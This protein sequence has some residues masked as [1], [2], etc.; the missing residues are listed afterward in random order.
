MHRRRLTVVLVVAASLW[1]AGSARPARTAGPSLEP[2]KV[3]RWVAQHTAA[4]QPAEFLVVLAE[5][6]DLRGAASL[7][8]RKAKG[9]F[10]H[11]ALLQ[12]A[13]ETQ[14]PLLAWLEANRIPHRSFYIANLIWV[15][16]DSAVVQALAARPEVAR[17]E[18]NPAIANSVR[19][20]TP[21]VASAQPNGVE[22]N[23]SYVHADA[24]WAQGFTG[25]GI[26]IGGQDTGYQWDH[27]ALK[28]HYRGWNGST[29]SHDYNW[30]DSIHTDN[31]D[32]L[33]DSPAPCDDHGHGTHTLGTA[34]GDDGAGNQIG[35]A[36]GAQW[37]GCRNM[38][39][40]VG[41]PAT[42]LECFEFFLAP[43]PVG[44]TPAQGDPDLAP[45]VT[46][47]SWGCP[48]SEGCT[49]DSLRLAVEAQRAA[50]IFTVVSAGNSGPSC[51]TIVDP[52]S[53]YDA[54]YTVGALVKGTDSLAAFSSHGPVTVDGSGRRKPDIAAP[55]TSI[56]SSDRLGTYAA[57]SGTSM[58]APHVAGAVAL[59]WSAHP[60]LRGQIDATEAVLNYSAR[61]LSSSA[62]GAS[63][64][65]NNTY[66][67]GRLDALAA[68]AGIH[69]LPVFFAGH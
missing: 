26:V 62:C 56:R 60:E 68:V 48:P 14:G 43:Y 24:V 32:C 31:S 9:R 59:L 46:N 3:S 18:G 49:F 5:Q 16:G 51:S 45:D 27:P 28:F 63:A 42:Y 6:A 61:D 1:L 36:P 55:G 13:R 50:G 52:P 34:L 33:G 8:T 57:M 40:G 35:M 39:D 7:P 20:T 37:I 22:A 41:T 64:V 65:P 19:W 29:A 54:A 21:A 58:A 17:L 38:N 47:N 66:G 44:G 69:F 11:A 10:V 2:G 67:Y 4:G 15:Q 53:L 30:H 25:Q 12:T 23:I